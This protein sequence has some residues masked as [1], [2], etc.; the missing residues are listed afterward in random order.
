MRLTAGTFL[1]YH[2]DSL[3]VL[4]PCVYGSVIAPSL[5]QSAMSLRF[6]QLPSLRPRLSNR[7][8]WSSRHA[9]LWLTY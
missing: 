7:I 5:I 4:Q 6:R 3:R 1:K 2:R 9:P 8:T